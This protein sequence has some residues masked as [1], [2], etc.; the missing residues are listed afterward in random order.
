MHVIFVLLETLGIVKMVG[1]EEGIVK[2]LNWI[3]ICCLTN[4]RKQLE[5]FLKTQ[6][7]KTHIGDKITKKQA[8]M[9][10]NVNQILV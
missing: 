3:G 7:R 4:K 6:K 9:I 8:K 1:I 10:K 2:T 5:T